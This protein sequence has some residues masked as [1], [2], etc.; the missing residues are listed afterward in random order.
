MKPADLVDQVCRSRLASLHPA[1]INERDDRGS[2]KIVLKGAKELS[3][4]NL[5]VHL[6]SAFPLERGLDHVR[7]I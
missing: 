5:N 1:Q 4:F 6:A 7:S 3:H 2:P